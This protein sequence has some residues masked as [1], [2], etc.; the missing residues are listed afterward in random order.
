MLQVARD[1]HVNVNQRERLVALRAL[2]DLI[3]HEPVSLPTVDGS[4]TVFNATQE[5]EPGL[6]RVRVLNEGG[7]EAHVTEVI[8]TPGNIILDVQ[9]SDLAQADITPGTWFELIAKGR[10]RRVFYGRDFSSVPRGQ[11]VVFPDADGFLL[12]A[13]NRGNAAA[14][15][16]LQAGDAVL[17]HRLSA[18]SAPEPPAP[19]R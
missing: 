17:V 1:G 9:S 7:F 13:R 15:T 2:L 18:E 14:T 3:G 6:S 8:A 11:W 19:A 4:S 10:P 12:L 16:G 5:P